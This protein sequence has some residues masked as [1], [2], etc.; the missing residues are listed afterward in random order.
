MID[1]TLI[2]V[3]TNIQDIQD[4]EATESQLLC[5]LSKLLL[6]CAI[7]FE[8]VC[9]VVCTVVIIL[10]FQTFLSMIS[11]VFV[12]YPRLCSTLDKV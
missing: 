5:D 10:T 11:L 1:H 3:M 7:H 8:K 2:K 9:A 4:I 6:D 12:S